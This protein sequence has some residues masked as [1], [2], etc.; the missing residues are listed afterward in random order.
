MVGSCRWYKCK[1]DVAGCSELGSEH[2]PLRDGCGGNGCGGV[3]DPAKVWHRVLV[4]C[5]GGCKGVYQA[6][7]VLTR[8]L[9]RC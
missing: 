1:Q 8:L 3:E 5:P 7:G 9:Q 2:G 4:F 6:L